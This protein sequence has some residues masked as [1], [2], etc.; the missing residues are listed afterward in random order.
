MAS[1]LVREDMTFFSRLM[2]GVLSG[3]GTNTG[4]LAALMCQMVRKY[5]SCL[6]KDIFSKTMVTMRRILF[7]GFLK[8][9]RQQNTVLLI[10][11]RLTSTVPPLVITRAVYSHKIQ[12]ISHRVFYSEFFDDFV[13]VSLPVTYTL[14]APAS[15]T[16]YPFFNL[17]FSISSF[18][19]VSRNRSNSESFLLV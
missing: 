1:N 18:A 7:M 4:I 9:L 12:E 19:T 6:V 13:I 10:A 15:S 17:A 16:Q 5:P 3:L 8:K 14:F 11:I 2:I